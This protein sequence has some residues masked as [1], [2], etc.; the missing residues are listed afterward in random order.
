[1]LTIV[2]V[3]LADVLIFVPSLARYRA[4][5]LLER[6]RQA[7][8]AALT[9]L[10]SDSGVTPE[11]EAELLANAGVYNV[12]LRRDDIRQLV[13]SSPVPEPVHADYDLRLAGPWQLIRDAL[14]AL[15]DSHDR[16]VRV[17]G[18]PVQ[19]GGQLIEITMPQ[20]PLRKAMLLYAWRLLMFSALISAVMAVLLFLAAQRLIVQPIR[21]VVLHMKAYAD[22]PEDARTV[23]EPSAR[24]E[25]L[26]EAEEML[27]TMQRQLTG[28]LKQRERLAQLGGAV[29]KISHDLRNI[30]TTAQLFADRIE[31]SA[32]PVVARS[33]PKLV[34]S[35]SRAVSLCEATLA[36]GK[37]EEAPPMLTRFPLAQ[38]VSEVLEGEGLEGETPAQ[39]PD[40]G[41]PG[42]G[43]VPGLVTSLTDI[44]ANLVLR[45]DREQ[46]YRVISNLVRNARQAIEAT[47]QPGT[48]EISAGESDSEWWLRVG[49]TGPG[50]PPRARE[51]LFA[52]FQGGVRKG[53][54]GLGLAISAELVRGHGGKLELLHSDSEGTEFMIHLPKLAVNTELQ[55]FD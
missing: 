35:I 30:L 34:G 19:E 33:A 15:F 38:L 20:E 5:F 16:V 45:A 12:V 42:E 47:G 24:V 43:A 18:N 29:A 55:Q 3:L 32:D 14:S 1:M 53:G 26:R 6:L 25:E 9:Q 10:A 52:A 7:Q 23:I 40:G 8:I 4:D 36:F 41:A 2:F 27:A 31:G 44:A 17:I 49:D 51:H 37:A 11:L 22:A 50:L 28:A 46:L 13:L 39:A 54:T 21:R 48:I